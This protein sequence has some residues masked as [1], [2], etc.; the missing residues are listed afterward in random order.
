MNPVQRRSPSCVVDEIPGSDSGTAVHCVGRR[1]GFDTDLPVIVYTD[2]MSKQGDEAPR[3]AEVF[4]LER[5]GDDLWRAVFENDHPGPVFGGNILGSATRAG[6][7]SVDGRPL[8][9]LHMH[10]LRPV[11][12]NVPVDFVVE[13]LRDGR[14]L[15]HRRVSVRADDK[16][17]AEL[18]LS[19]AAAGSGRDL[20]GTTSVAEWPRPESLPSEEE[21]AR[22]QGWDEH[23]LSPLEWRWIGDVW[24]PRPGEPTSYRSWVRPRLPVGDEPGV[25]PAAIAF[26]SDFHSHY[27]VARALGG[28]EHF[29]PMGFTSL[30]TV[31]WLHR[32]DVWDD[33]RLLVTDCDVAHGG[34]ALTRRQLYDASGALLVSMAQEALIAAG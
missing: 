12:S 16:L 21:V 28:G 14:R 30:D 31:I 6:A 10:F 11:A 8:A 32:D 23:W 33:W 15:A 19:F 4:A 1:A 27:S 7:L 2:P 22:A 18:V 24:H 29:E 9:A 26:L 25:Y 13:R 20:N 17:C 3:L 34:R 5:C